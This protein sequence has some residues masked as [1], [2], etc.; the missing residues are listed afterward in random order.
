MRHNQPLRQALG[1]ALLD[2]A[3]MDDLV[4]WLRGNL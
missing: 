3:G 4:E 2:F 1:E